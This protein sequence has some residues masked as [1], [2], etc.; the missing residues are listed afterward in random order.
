MTGDELSELAAVPTTKIIRVPVS[1]ACLNF[2]ANADDIRD[3]YS[4]HQEAKKVDVKAIYEKLHV[5][6]KAVLVLVAALWEAYCEDVAEE[7]LRLLVQHAPNWEALPR[8]LLKAVA[9]ELRR[10]DEEFAPWTLAGEGWR[11]YLLDRLYLL[12]QKRNYSF[13]T[14]KAKNVDALFLE[15]VGIV[16]ISDAWTLPLGVEWARNELDSF[17]DKR[18]VI[19]HRYEPGST[20]AKRHVKQFYN[21]VSGLVARTDAAVGRVIREVTG[22]NRWSATSVPSPRP[23]TGTASSL[24]Q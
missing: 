21:L 9:K 5:A 13:A 1:N 4:L 16:R 17:I 20:V 19:A 23:A 18:N 12:G 10:L 8:P 7:G 11:Q 24:D 3:F 22:A 6:N 15:S 2:V 14:P